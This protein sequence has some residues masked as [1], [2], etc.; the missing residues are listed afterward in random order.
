[1]TDHVSP[2]PFKLFDACYFHPRVLGHPA[3]W[4]AVV[5][6]NA[7]GELAPGIICACSLQSEF[8][9]LK[10]A[11]SGDG[12]QLA[13]DDEVLSFLSLAGFVIRRVFPIIFLI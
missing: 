8:L 3:R 1:L 2:F 5:V 4:K 6:K 10:I 11:Q 7:T 13:S 12:R 9:M